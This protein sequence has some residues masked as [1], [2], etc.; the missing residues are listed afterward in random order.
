MSDEM[1]AASIHV[2]TEPTLQESTENITSLSAVNI[3]IQH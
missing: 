2:T 1:V 3:V